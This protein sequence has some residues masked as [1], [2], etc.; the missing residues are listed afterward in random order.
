MDLDVL[1]RAIES[2]IRDVFTCAPARV[3][4]YDPS[5]MT[6]SLRLGVKRPI[7]TEEG[8]VAHESYPE[9]PDVPIAFPRA[10][11][12][13]LTWP[14]PAGSWVLYVGL[15][16]SPS[17]WRKGSP[18][19]QEGGAE[20]RDTRHAHPSHGVAIPCLGVDS[21]ALDGAGESAVCIVGSEVRLG[22]HDASDFVALASLVESELQSIQTTLATGKAPSGGGPVTFDTPYVPGQVAATKV[23]AE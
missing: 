19:G 14:I 3:V 13:S 23:K 15:T 12:T 1:R 4:S 20:P 17:E 7:A 10:G 5:T 2:Q 11:S 18:S 21:Q 6:A 9:I 8:D 16:W 22:A